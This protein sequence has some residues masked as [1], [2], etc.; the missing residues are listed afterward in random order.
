MS[1][2]N[3]SN[4][5]VGA[6]LVVG[7]GI[8]GMQAA[9]DLAE[10]GIK[11]YLLERDTSIGGG[12]VRLDKTF[13]TNDCAMCT[14]G[15]RLVGVGR[16]LNIEMITGADV[17]KV[18][19]EP[20]NY[21][22]T[23]KKKNRW[24]DI[25]KC[26][27]CGDCTK[28]CP[29][30]TDSLF[31]QLL[32]KENAVYRMFPQA[33][34]GA[35]AVHKEGTSPCRI[36]CPA[37]V[38]PHAYVT[39]LAAGKVQEAFDVI[40]QAMPFAGICGRVCHHPC[41][42]ECYRGKLMKEPVSI[43]ALKR[44][45]AD[46]YYAGRYAVNESAEAKQ[47]PSPPVPRTEKIAIVGAGP[48]GLTCAR[49]LAALGYPV[50]IFDSA[51]D[52]GGMVRRVIPDYR[53]PYEL[54]KREVDAILQKG[55]E[56][57][58]KTTVG[59]D[60]SF[61][62]LREQYQAVFV[63]VGAQLST[64][65]DIPGED[66]EGV[67]PALTL[68]EESNAGRK[69]RLGDRVVVVGGGN[70]AMDAAR[71]A[72]RLGAREVTVVYRRSRAEMPAS[73]WEIEEAEEE[74]INFHYLA[75]PVSVKG[76][77]KKAVAL[78]C[79]RMRLGEPDA[80]GRRRPEPVPGSEFEIPVESI[81]PAIGQASDLGFL[82]G[83]VELN[84]N[85]TIKA[86]SL[87]L[88]TS[89]DGVFAGGDVVRGPASIVEAVGHGHEATISIDRYLS[90]L[91][92]KEGRGKRPEVP[93]EP[94]TKGAVVRGRVTQKRLSPEERKA[95]FSEVVLPL[96]K[97]EAI[98]EAERCLACAVC[99][100]CRQCEKTCEAKA[101][102]HDGPHEEL[103]DLN[104]GAVL[105]A[106]GYKLYDAKAKPEL[107]YGRYPNVLTA[108]QFERILAPTGPFS[109]H[110]CR[111]FD[112]RMPHK[113]AFIQCVGSRDVSREANLN[114]CSAVCCMYATKQA[115]L[116]KEEH[117]ETDVAIFYID[118]RTFGKG[119]EGFY[120][121]AKKMGIRYIRFKPSYVEEIP[122]DLDLRIRY[123][124]DSGETITEEFNLVILSCGM[125]PAEENKEL[126]E[127]F[128]F[129]LNEFGFC[130]T[131]MFAPVET[132]RQGIYSLGAFNGPKDISESVTQGSAAVV[133]ALSLL[134]DAKGTMVRDKVYPPERDVAGEDARIGVFICHCGK[135]I[136]SVVDVPAAVEYAKS[137]P[138][139]VY[140]ENFLYACSA[141]SGERMKHIIKEY[142]LNR[143]VVASCTPRTHE[144]LF[145]ENMKEA[146]LNPYL[147]EMANIRDQC[148]WVHTNEPEMATKK[149]KDIIKMAV[150]KSKLREPLY[151]KVIEVNHN[152]LVIGGGLAGMTASLDL[153]NQ[154]FETWLLEQ[155]DILG[156][157]LRR[158]KFLLDGQDPQQR[159]QD[160]IQKVQNH[161]KIKVFMK[162]EILKSEGSVADFK[163][164]FKSNG[165]THTL[166]HGA[167]IIA[168]GA[169]E[170]KPQEYLYGQNEKVMTQLEL[171]DKLAKGEFTA[172]TVVM[173]QCVGSREEAR[174]YCSRVCCSQ[175][176]KN[177]LKIKELKP[178]TNVFILY[179]D[180][181]T[182][183]FNEQHY[184]KAREK[185]VRFIRYEEDKKP[186]VTADGSLAVTFYDPLLRADLTINTDVVVL[187]TGTVSRPGNK[188]IAE[189]LRVPL[190]QDNF[191]QE[192]HLKLR[193][194]DFPADGLYVC[195][196]GHAPK[197][198]EET[199]TQAS[200][201]A[202]RASTILSKKRIQS[203]ATISYV[204]EEVC[205]GCGQCVAICA[206]GA[207][208]LDPVK[209]T[210]MVRETVCQGC[211]AC[212]VTCPSKAIRHR[213]WNPKQFFEMIEAAGYAYAKRG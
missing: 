196:I 106:A 129:D 3:G 139:V 193:P 125:G 45:I 185:G 98:A 33:V 73:P 50:T 162:T 188:V 155:S 160:M 5:K 178:E 107:G 87:T 31:Q 75:A 164:E 201:A 90:N 177:A 203:E 52:G 71:T 14:I 112:G 47:P 171:E 146:G 12:M 130:K 20:G 182:Y 136:A 24:V 114:Y 57:R 145:Q 83:E 179:R 94:D 210:A 198:V 49:D 110:I 80:S 131:D 34:P 205:R 169:E 66:L 25:D 122:G 121:R 116:L 65:L 195:G 181:R 32:A 18:G 180:L 84:K 96:T 55:I 53:L 141:D 119:Y 200:A 207:L 138:N 167:V 212:A 194:V 89:A 117:P 118:M 77:G 68:L 61:A 108:L 109:G 123:I 42:T 103:V 159:L 62:D 46:E 86:D 70:V 64:K 2:N 170:Y 128:G 105:L 76:D 23:I 100:E 101:I 40:Y 99:C 27:G 156:G 150:Y 151:S 8:G 161:P 7:A 29:V 172:N 191:F 15:P 187:S 208:E 85:G 140:A 63:A 143:M 79:T 1:G 16:H 82:K 211:G 166:T 22:V 74:G 154:G 95:N 44:Y 6:A 165:E 202:A 92:L 9:L 67:I 144:P 30:K 192:A 28:N 97:E 26:K 120:D 36:A 213:N 10:A 72:L 56:M 93:P 69:P 152:C 78:V 189:M 91:D 111:P 126:A 199:I 58:S 127:K 11:V 133:K 157:N 37:G 113:V 158:L 209:K 134:A 48:A 102:C 81:I 54:V 51:P 19:G 35:F 17:E 148:S 173:I 132:T 104:V 43:C 147:F 206:Y 168:T 124:N 88:Q 135:N 197:N 176:V 186:A 137:L 115:I 175:A 163:T 38:N 21:T 59:N 190:N 142:A 174:P 149:A 39:L 41:E 183:A 204:D 4:G 153:A 184:Y 60:I 13:P